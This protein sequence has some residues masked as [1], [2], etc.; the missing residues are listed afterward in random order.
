MMTV[1]LTRLPGPVAAEHPQNIEIS[2]PSLKVYMVFL[3]KMLSPDFQYTEETLLWPNNSIFVPV[4]HKTFSEGSAYSQSTVLI[5]MLPPG[6]KS[7]VIRP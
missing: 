1:T 4:D 5:K 6:K 3:H 7:R 2:P